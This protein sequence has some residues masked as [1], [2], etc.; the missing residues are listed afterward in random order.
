MADIA[1]VKM[2]HLEFI[3]SV[4][5]RMNLNSFLL[6]G[7][8]VTLLTGILTVE[9]VHPRPEFLIV[10]GLPILLFWALDGYYLHVERMFR[11]RYDAVRL[12]AN[13]ETDFDMTPIPGAFSLVKAL[14]SATVLPFHGCLA[15][16]FF[17]L[18]VCLS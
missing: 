16:A 10:G 7:W 6:K 2:K 4:I 17:T 18:H 15:A 9:T 5:A 14:L 8:S 1:D 12:K 3:Q 13:D 11:R